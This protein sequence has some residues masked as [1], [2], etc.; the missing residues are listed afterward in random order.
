MSNLYRTYDIFLFQYG[1]FSISL[2]PHNF[3][4][5]V[6]RT[7]SGNYIYT[8]LEIVTDAWNHVLV[9]YDL[10]NRTVTLNLNSQLKIMP[11][12][13]K[14][15]VLNY[16]NLIF[17]SVT[18][19]LTSGYLTQIKLWSYVL[20]Q[21]EI[22]MEMSADGYLGSITSYWDGSYA[23]NVFYDY[24]GNNHANVTGGKN[25]TFIV[26]YIYKTLLMCVNQIMLKWV[27]E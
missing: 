5:I 23:P 22:D 24:W 19:A 1:S 2:D 27:Q 12:P 25:I 9:A 6:A 16:G 20:S 21:T 26:T 4:Q 15:T 3:V 7:E 17:G 10:Q 8:G 13:A 11:V 18:P 14:P